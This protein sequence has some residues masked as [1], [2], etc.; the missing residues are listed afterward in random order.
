MSKFLTELEIKL[1]PDCDG[2]YILLAPL[3]Y[4]S[5][6]LKREIYIPDGL[7]TDF[8]SVPRVPIIYER[9]GNK[10]HREAVLHDYSFRIDSDPVVSFM[11]ANG[12]FLEAMECRGKSFDVRYGMYAGVVI[13]GYPSY[14]KRR[15][16][17]VL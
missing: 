10:A 16:M 3:V 9:F 11:V 6:K 1:R 14:H 15:V 2:I 13:G 8:A 7:Q 4:Y 5:S 17:D 12:L